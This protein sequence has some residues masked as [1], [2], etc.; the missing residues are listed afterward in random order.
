M[1]HHVVGVVQRQ[2][3]D[4]RHHRVDVA[5]AARLDLHRLGAEQVVDDG[6][7][8]RREVPQHVHVGLE[9]AEVDALRVVIGD[10]A[11]RIGADQVLQ[12]PNHGVEDEGVVDHQGQA[13]GLGT[14]DEFG[15]L[16]AGAAEWFFHQHVLAGRDRQRG[17]RVVGRHRR[18]DHHGIDM[19][20][21]GVEVGENA[22]LRGLGGDPLP[23]FP[24][25]GRPRPRD[26][27]PG[28]A[29][30]TRKRF[31]PQYPMPHRAT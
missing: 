4:V 16:I 3:A 18:R 1:C 17:E 27:G 13:R 25:S 26:A 31:L 19:R 22:D 9:Q 6:E 29:P 24:P 10:L 11:Q 8:V 12:H 5:I 30:S 21:G 15:R 20:Q 14:F 23:W 28:L 7:V 2:V